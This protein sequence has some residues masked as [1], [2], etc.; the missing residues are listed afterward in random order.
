MA[1]SSERK[2]K[3]R[4]FLIA[5]D[6]DWREAFSVDVLFYHVSELYA[7]HSHCSGISVIGQSS[8]ESSQGTGPLSP[9]G[10]QEL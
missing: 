4:V 6:F 3:R 2:E 5:L 8:Q 9:D 1:F 7:N 10:K